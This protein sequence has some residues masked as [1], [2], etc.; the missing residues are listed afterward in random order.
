M[1][2]PF[3]L[4]NLD[5]NQKEKEYNIR[6]QN[7]TNGEVTKI[8]KEEFQLENIKLSIEKEHINPFPI[9][10][11]I[12]VVVDYFGNGKNF[13]AKTEDYIPINKS[14]PQHFLRFSIN[15]KNSE[16]FILNI[17]LVIYKIDEK[18]KKTYIPVLRAKNSTYNIFQSSE[19]NE[20][21]E[22]IDK[23]IGFSHSQGLKE[24]KVHDE[25]PEEFYSIDSINRDNIPYISGA[26]TNK[27]FGIEN[28]GNTCFL[29]S[30]LQILIHSPIFIENF[31][32]DI[33]KFKPKHG[34]VAYAFY[35][36]IMNIYSRDTD[37]FTPKNLIHTFLNKCNQFS[38]GEQ[39]DSQRFYRYLATILEKE[40]GPS[41]TCIKNSFEGK[42][43]YDNMFIC[44]NAFCS[45]KDEKKYEQQFY[46]IF[47]S[48]PEN[49]IESSINDLIYNTY[50][51]NQELISNKKCGCG[52]HFKLN[53][54]IFILP[55]K[56]L[57]VN[58]QKGKIK[59]RS[60]K[61]TI[62]KIDNIYL[63]ENSYYEPYAI[64]CHSG[65]MD[66]GHYYSYIK[67][68]NKKDKLNEGEWYR[69]NDED[70]KKITC[71]GSSSEII[72][73]FYKEKKIIK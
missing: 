3:A 48:V 40:F 22:N 58:I 37:I 28:L 63:K 30:S 31:L 5:F 4:I 52:K 54:N 41:N 61:K 71:P 57:S 11:T 67:I 32:Y 38:L 42:F 62:I 72:N 65:K 51:K 24:K 10:E 64:N 47:V 7:S 25:V 19:I 56:Y 8:M 33:V 20:E 27:I 60:L 9:F 44:E 16:E 46:D 1:S 59:T 55:N 26:I 39:S 23:Q 70:Y 13:L 49:S 29:N 35:N 45:K 2:K 66:Y 36:F 34:T 50:K 53:R 14:K 18:D 43:I 21:T 69:F 6:V 73:I 12:K 17:S 68:D 15:G